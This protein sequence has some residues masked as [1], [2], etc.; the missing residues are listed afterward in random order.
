MGRA[1]RGMGDPTGIARRAVKPDVVQLDARVVSVETGPCAQTTGKSSVGTHVIVK[2]SQGQEY[3][4][5]LGPAVMVRE[6]AGLLVGGD[7]VRLKVFRT[8]AM[9]QG[10]YVCVEMASGDRTVVLR[11]GGL[12]PVWAGRMSRGTDN[13][14]VRPLAGAGASEP[15]RLGYAGG[16]GNRGGQ[17][18]MMGRG[19]GGGR[20]FRAMTR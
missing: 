9:P 20:G 5:H 8:D 15:L 12:R 11:D 16:R 19:R 2:T 4:V 17:G 18:M 10:H 1:Q 3:N 7:S 14:S 6:A 13:T